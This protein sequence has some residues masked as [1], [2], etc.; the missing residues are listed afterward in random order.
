[1]LFSPDVPDVGH[2][3]S[4]AT[5]LYASLWRWANTRYWSVLWRSNSFVRHSDNGGYPSP[6]RSRRYDIED[7]NAAGSC[8]MYQRCS[9]NAV[10]EYTRPL[11]V[12]N[13]SLSCVSHD[14]AGA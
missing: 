4:S 13:S 6:C 12:K 10:S 5:A 3:G 8:A 11:L 14:R 7:R 1:M 2:R 9:S